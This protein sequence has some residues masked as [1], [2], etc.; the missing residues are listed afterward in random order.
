MGENA[1]HVLMVNRREAEVMELIDLAVESFSRPKLRRLFCAQADGGFF[2]D[3]PMVYYGG[4]VLSYAVAF[5]MKKPFARMLEQMVDNEKMQ[6][7][8]EGEETPDPALPPAGFFT[9]ALLAVLPAAHAS[10]LL[11][12]FSSRLCLTNLSLTPGSTL[13]T[14]SRSLFSLNNSE[15]HSCHLSGFLPLHTCIANGLT[16][17]YDFLIDFKGLP[18]EVQMKLHP[19]RADPNALTARGTARIELCNL[20]PLQLAVKLGNKRMFQHALRKSCSVYWQWGPVTCYELDLTPI[21]S[22]NNGGNDVMELVGRLDATDST[23]EMLME[24]F[25]QGFLHTLFVEKWRRFARHWYWLMRLL[26]IV[27]FSMLIALSLCLK[28]LPPSRFIYRSLP[29]VM[30]LLAA[31]IFI[32]ECRTVFLWLSNFRNRPERQVPESEANAFTKSKFKKVRAEHAEPSTQSGAR[33]EHV[34]PPRRD[35]LA[36]APSLYTSPL[37]LASTPRLCT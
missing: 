12:C 27:Y 4:T 35:D 5:S 37:H 22:F 34:V 7:C 20:T 24:D 6:G 16:S 30:L 8:V 11:P 21:D 2:H 13:A 9:A 32:L 23:K 25:M 10:C 1:F 33:R 14:T 17:M 3:L 19:F 18:L 26:D 36:S 31:P 28:F 15:R 29:V